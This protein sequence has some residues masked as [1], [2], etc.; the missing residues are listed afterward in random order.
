MYQQLNSLN[1][2]HHHVGIKP[3]EDYVKFLREIAERAAALRHYTT[4]SGAKYVTLSDRIGPGH[5]SFFVNALINEPKLMGPD[6]HIVGRKGRYFAAYF[7][8]AHGFDVIRFDEFN[9]DLGHIILI[10]P[11]R[12][13][14]CRIDAN[15][16]LTNDIYTLDGRNK[17]PNKPIEFEKAI[18]LFGDSL[19]VVVPHPTLMMEGIFRRSNLNSNGNTRSRLEGIVEQMRDG[20]IGWESY[21]ASARWFQRPS[22]MEQF[23]QWMK[24]S[25]APKG[26]VANDTEFDWIGHNMMNLWIPDDYVPKLQSEEEALKLLDT[27][28]GQFVHALRNGYFDVLSTKPAPW[29]ALERKLRKHIAYKTRKLLRIEY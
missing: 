8:G 12:E 14:F 4:I 7:D 23:G 22:T 10:G 17:I 2:N 25:G 16:G 6:C 19:Y 28:V 24:E 29:D 5:Y 15:G 1:S 9:T 11:K 26:M 20:K 21:N 18:E 3:S 13:V 27:R